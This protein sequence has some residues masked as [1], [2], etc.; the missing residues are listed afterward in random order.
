MALFLLLWGGEGGGEG[1]GGGGKRHLFL[2]LRG[3]WEE[4]FSVSNSF[5]LLRGL[6]GGG[7]LEVG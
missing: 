2:K 5:Y 7:D 1:S 3:V 4:D 6:R